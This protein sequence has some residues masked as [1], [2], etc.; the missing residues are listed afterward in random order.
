MLFLIFSV[1]LYF[2]PTIIAR[3]LGLR[4]AKVRPGASRSGKFRPVLQPVR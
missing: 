3:D 2:L 1:L 4:G